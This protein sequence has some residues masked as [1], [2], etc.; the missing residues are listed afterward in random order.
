MILAGI[1]AARFTVE[2]YYEKLIAPRQ[3]FVP[4]PKAIKQTLSCQPIRMQLA[5]VLAYSAGTSV[6]GTLGFYTTI[7]YVCGS[8]LAEGAEW[9]LAMGI[10]GM[11]AG[12]LGVGLFNR[13]AAK[14]GKRRGMR[15]VQVFAMVAFAATWWLYTP[16]VKW[17]QIGATALLS[18]SAAGFWLLH[19]SMG[20]DA[21][22]FDELKSGTR[23]EGA[24]AA[25]ISFTVK[26]AGVFGTLLTGALLS[27]AGFQEKMDAPQSEE[28]LTFIRLGLALV[29]ITGLAFAQ[30]A[31]TR[32]T[33][34]KE[35]ASAVR[36]Q[37]EAEREKSAKAPRGPHP[38]S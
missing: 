9:N 14:I 3:S 31:L 33:M 12:A 6:V 36:Q 28:T 18:I 27:V 30:I 19:V 15:A 32:S 13:I 20:A 29:P 37:L 24:Y 1:A 5:M 22:A 4:F 10:A 2:P 26:V 8:D 11:L 17:L 34:S 16:E 7:Y 25:C 21:I 35:R 38:T 23:R